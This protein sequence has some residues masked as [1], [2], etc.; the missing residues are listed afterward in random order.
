VS[1]DL[2]RYVIVIG[3]L[4]LLLA[5]TIAFCVYSTTDTSGSELTAHLAHTRDATPTSPLDRQQ[6]ALK[7]STVHTDDTKEAVEKLLGKPDDILRAPDLVPI[8]GDEYWCYG[9]EGHKTFPTLGQI[10]FRKNR[11]FSVVGGGQPNT[12]P[13]A[14]IISEKD[15]RAALRFIYP[16]ANFGGAKRL[17]EI[18][19][20]GNRTCDPLHL[21]R[22]S[23]YLQVM[24]KPKAM[25][26]LQEYHRLGAGLDDQNWLFFLLRTLFEVPTSPGSMP[27]LR[28]G[29]MVPPPPTDPKMIPRFPIVLVD[30][31]PFSLIWGTSL[32]GQAEPLSIQLEYFRRVGKIRRQKFF[33]PTDPYLSYEHLLG[34]KEWGY[35]IQTLKKAER[36]RDQ[37][38]AVLLQVIALTRTVYDSPEAQRADPVPD[39]SEYGRHHANFLR[40]TARWNES[41]QL[42]V[43]GDGSHYQIGADIRTDACKDDTP[44]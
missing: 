36:I 9:T 14:E 16:G 32:I 3:G 6:F 21:I 30:D 24:G 19:I 13:A 35:V 20:G 37:Q 1:G 18:P 33:P 10:Q 29:M 25:T 7:L 42:Y 2:R 4:R 27:D 41:L 12:V 31:I 5:V 17:N 23:N 44:D 40:T 11:V 38:G 8:K 15:L 43:R 34:S 26:V 39:P 28:I 22:V